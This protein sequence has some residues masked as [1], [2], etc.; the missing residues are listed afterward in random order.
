MTEHEFNPFQLDVVAFAKAAGHVEGHWPLVRLD[1]LAESA[2][3]EG[4]PTETVG[5]AWSARGE[6][7]PARGG[8]PQPWLHVKAQARI[9]LECQRCLR[10][11]EVILETDRSFL[12]VPG[13]DTAA[14]IDADSEHDVLA[15]TTALNLRE[16]VE[17]ELLLAMPL[18]P[19]HD[20]C[21]VPLQAP[22]NDEEA[23]QAPN[24]FAAL[25]ALKRNGDLG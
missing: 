19:R 14:K 3:A 18:V 16:L 22:E 13:E 25:A 15:L 7:R 12:F 2:V 10:P 23:M 4:S 11:V 5:V 8:G 24:P 21:P 9:A 6:S 1:R 20:V 17:D